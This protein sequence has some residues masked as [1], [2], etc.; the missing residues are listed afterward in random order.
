MKIRIFAKILLFL[1]Q[2]VIFGARVFNSK[3]NGGGL[4]IGLIFLRFLV[5][6]IDHRLVIRLVNRGFVC[7]HLLCLCG[8]F[9]V[10]L[11]LRLFE[12]FGSFR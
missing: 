5:Q 9:E 7:I 2:F 3:E 8:Y 10:G 11:Y 6:V 12:Q 4:Q 1:R